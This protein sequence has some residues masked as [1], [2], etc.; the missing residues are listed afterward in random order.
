[1]AHFECSYTA[2]RQT[3]PRI[4][5]KQCV[6]MHCDVL[7]PVN[8]G[9]T[10]DP[11][12]KELDRVKGVTRHALCSAGVSLTCR[13]AAVE[14]NNADGSVMKVGVLPPWV[15]RRWPQQL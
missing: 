2:V 12:V 5:R 15:R 10:L 9:I 14:V 3:C 4:S 1:M 8:I 11:F 6:H 13:F 7:P